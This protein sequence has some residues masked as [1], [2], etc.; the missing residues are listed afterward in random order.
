MSNKQLRI[1][2]RW[3]HILTAA[4][5]GTFVY[6]PLRTDD[7]FTLFMQVVVIPAAAITGIVLWQQPRAVK[8]FKQLRQPQHES[9]AR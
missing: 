1:L 5:L 8:F 9:S 6:S 4:L 7:T 2:T 3:V